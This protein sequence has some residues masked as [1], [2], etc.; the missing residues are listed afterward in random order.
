MAE[1]GEKD[2][3]PRVRKPWK[4]RPLPPIEP[5]TVRLLTGGN[6]QI[7]K[8]DGEAP[9]AAYIAAMPGWKS[10]VGRRIDD[11]VREVVPDAARAV[12]WNA[13]FWGVPG[14]GWML[15][16]SCTARYVKV[17]FLT[18]SA[19]HP[20]PPEASKHPAMRYLHLYE[21]TSLDQ[22]QFADWLRQAAAI[23]GDTLF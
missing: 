10:T 23:P 21:D 6:P 15:S 16:L 3:A 20:M 19:L 7:A 13:P 1:N 22:M 14:Q 18:G 9:V 8:A 11:L 5:G 17:A 4:P 12:R 2:R